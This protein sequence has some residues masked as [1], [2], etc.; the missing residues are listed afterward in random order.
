R[1]QATNWREAEQRARTP[2]DSI[3][4]SLPTRASQHR[5]SARNR[6]NRTE[7]EMLEKLTRAKVV[8][9]AGALAL[10][11]CTVMATAGPASARPG[12][13]HHHGFGLGGAIVG[14]VIGGALAAATAP[15]WGPDNYAYDDYPGYAYGPAYAYVPAPGPVVTGGGVAYCEAHFRSYNPA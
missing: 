14:G 7:N 9:T 5:E 11:A 15:Y 8:G 13:H 4:A 2:I 6:H 12:P 10:S 1:D 3:V